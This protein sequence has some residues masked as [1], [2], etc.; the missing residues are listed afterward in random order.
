MKKLLLLIINNHFQNF[1]YLLYYFIIIYKLLEISQNYEKNFLF[2]QNFMET[3]L[4]VLRCFITFAFSN[5]Y[6]KI[7]KKTFVTFF[8][9]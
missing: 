1:V 2:K 6:L 8:N 9:N 3:F 5:N 7:E 4:K